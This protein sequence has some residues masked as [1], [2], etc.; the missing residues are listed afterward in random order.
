MVCSSIAFTITSN[1][2]S[3]RTS[4]SRT[5][6]L[7]KQPD[8]L[9]RHKGSSINVATCEDYEAHDYDGDEEYEAGEVCH[10]THYEGGKTIEEEFPGVSSCCPFHGHI[11]SAK[12]CQGKDKEGKKAVF[13]VAEVCVKPIEGEDNKVVEKMNLNCRTKTVKGTFDRKKA[14]LSKWL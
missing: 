8:Y 2:T 14:N 9:Q 5:I 11:S 4:T 6:N 3:T 13:N 7:L 12:N 1:S 10:Y